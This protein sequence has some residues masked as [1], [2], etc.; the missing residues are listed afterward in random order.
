MNIK[1][2][3][4]DG[5]EYVEA[6]SDDWETP[7]ELFR[8]LD[9]EFDFTLDPCCKEETTKCEKYFTVEVNGLKKSW[10]NERV[11]MNCPYSQIEEWVKKVY[12]ERKLGCSLVVALLPAWT[13]RGWFHRFIYPDHAEVRFLEGRVKFLL[14]G[15]TKDSPP[16]GSMIVIFKGLL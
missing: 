12:I 6:T 5:S 9:K 15:Q 11:F 3:T 14:N 1:Q 7:K 13:D 4:I 10:R 2:T 8:Q 16:F